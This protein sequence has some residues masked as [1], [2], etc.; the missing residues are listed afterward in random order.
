M[1]FALSYVLC[2][3]LP[4]NAWQVVSHV[5]GDPQRSR[6]LGSTA[7][8]EAAVVDFALGFLDHDL[9]DPGIFLSRTQA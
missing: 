1:S 9:S 4:F 6:V 7:D 5:G 8:E 3:H 2:P